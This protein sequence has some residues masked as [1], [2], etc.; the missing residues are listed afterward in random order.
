MKKTFLDILFTLAR[1]HFFSSLFLFFLK[2]YAFDLV[3]KGSSN[4]II[5]L[6]QLFIFF[7]PILQ[8]V[9]W[10]NDTIISFNVPDN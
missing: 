1:H 7:E 8:A 6:S 4:I 5:G 3:F 10:I 9:S 2:K